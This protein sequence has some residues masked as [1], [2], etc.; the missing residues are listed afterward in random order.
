M[1][2]PEPRRGTT[3]VLA[4]L[5]GLVTD[6]AFPGLGWWPAAFLGIALL[7]LALARDSARWNLL[8]GTAWG[9]GFFLPHLTWIEGAVGSV[10]WVALA[11]VEALFVGLFGAA[12]GWA[13]RGAVT[14][15]A[16]RLQVPV[17]VVLWVGIEELRSSVPFGGFPWG[18]LAFAQAD[19][20]LVRWAWLGGAPLVSAAVVTAGVTLAL[21]LVALRRLDIG[22]ASGLVLLAAAP[23]V[24]GLFLPLDRSTTGEE[25]RTASVQGNVPDRG[26]DSLSQARE[27]LRNHAAGTHAVA[28]QVGAGELD[29]VIWPENGADRNPVTDA[30]SFE[31]VEGAAAAVGA[32]LLIGTL[33]YPETGGRYN[34]SMLWEPGVGAVHQYAKRRPAPFA[35]YIPMRSVARIFSAEVDRVRTDM[36]AGTELGLIPVDVPRLGREVGVATVICFEVAYDAIV[37]EH[38]AAGGEVLIIQ[39]NNATFGPTDESLQQLAMSRLRAVEHGRAT[40]Q[41]STVGVSAVISPAGVISQQTGHFTAEQMV[42]DLPLRSTETP[43]TRFGQAIAW[44]FAA[45]ALVV[46]VAGTVGAGK[47]PRSQREVS[48]GR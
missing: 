34:I 48:H 44:L 35:E 20:P 37:R 10:P 2:L 29:L 16:A 3:L 39:T 33:E 7:F 41:I 12:W 31:L 13:R 25:L 18:R 28:Q 19:S 38:V 17:F 21:T 46:T 27:V 47:F 24:V 14:W 1:P 26:L 4:I 40:V 43:A 36:L 5:G 23:V 45:A 6:T 8:V 22:L 30:E 32:P 9:L 15:R 11:L 42:A